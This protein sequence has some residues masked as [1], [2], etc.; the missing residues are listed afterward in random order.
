MSTTTPTVTR[1]GGYEIENTSSITG[2]H[3]IFG[4]RRTQRYRIAGN[5]RAVQ[6]FA[7]FVDGCRPA[8][9]KTAKIF[10]NAH[11]HGRV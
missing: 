6:T 5:F 1:D 2:H 8:K 9:I 3:I 11:T 7:F 4:R 10:C